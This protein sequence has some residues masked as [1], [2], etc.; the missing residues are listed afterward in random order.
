MDTLR[1]LLA[2]SVQSDYKLLQLNLKS[3]LNL[4]NVEKLVLE[5]QPLSFLGDLWTLNDAL[6]SDSDWISELRSYLNHLHFYAVPR[7]NGLYFRKTDNAVI[8]ACGDRVIVSAASQTYCDSI[9]REFAQK[10]TLEY[11][12][13]PNEIFGLKI[14][15]SDKIIISSDASAIVE[16]FK[17]ELKAANLNESVPLVSQSGNTPLDEEQKEKFYQGVAAVNYLSGLSRTDI[18]YAVSVLRAELGTPKEADWKRLLH[19]LSYLQNN[20]VKAVEYTKLPEHEFEGDNATVEAS[21][22]LETGF[23][24]KFAGGLV[25]WESKHVVTFDSITH[26]EDATTNQMLAYGNCARYVLSL[27]GFVDETLPMKTK[28]G[29]DF[30]VRMLN[31]AAETE[32]ET[33][34]GCHGK[35]CCC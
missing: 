11:S 17:A 1:L 35:D 29:R 18:A 20:P 30:L 28:I 22:S 15:V 9:E 24:W 3:P 13:L 32:S 31:A 10:Y 6:G 25:Y 4:A 5:S 21:G 16:P 14:V 27:V 34:S 12:G 19:L 7:T 33:H 23:Y 8:F 2:A 26:V